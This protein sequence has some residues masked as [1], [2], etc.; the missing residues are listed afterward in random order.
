MI[1][2]AVVDVRSDDKTV[3]SLEN[4]GFHVIPTVK[5]DALY[6]AVASHAD[7]Q[8]HYLGNNT[9]I[10]A[11][12]VFEH[13]KKLLPASFK[14]IKGASKLSDKYPYDIAYNAAQ[15]RDFIICREKYTSPEILEQGRG[16]GKKIIDVKQGYAKC[17]TC[18]VS[19]SAII[20]ADNGI[21]SASRM[22]GIDALHIT[23]GNIEL[24]G[25]DSGFIGG[26]TGLLEKNLLAVNGDIMTHPNADEIKQFCKKHKTEII[27]LKDGIL[28]DI[29]TVISNVDF[30]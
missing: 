10:S 17:S 23:D 11:P 5:T 6:D 7:M 9:F 12:E 18:I 1:K 29:G 15:L 8:I 14:L 22:A 21:A 2:T 27:C 13:Y 19:G 3:Y 26:A 24:R 25:L 4:I 16:Q 28:T 20:T 30:D